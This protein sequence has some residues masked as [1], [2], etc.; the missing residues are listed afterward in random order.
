MSTPAWLGATA[1]ASGPGLAAQVN[2]FLGTHASVWRY[3]GSTLVSAQATGAAVYETTASQYWAQAITTG[4]SQTVIGQLGLQVSTVG[5]SPTSA[6]IAPLQVSL[7]AD[8]SGPTGAALA[9][10]TLAETYVYSAPFWLPVPLSV[11]GLTPSTRY[12]VVTAPVGNSSAYYVWQH[13]NQSTGALVS[14]DAVTWSNEAFGLMY[15]VYDASGT[16]QIT[17]FTDDDGARVTVLTYDA[18]NR[19][20]TITEYTTAQ[21]GALLTSTRTLTYSGAYLTGVS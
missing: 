2:Q 4:S 14:S 15:Q 16:G 10:V 12:W 20:S 13:S 17:S 18:S 3:T 9:G 7:Y 11:T 1:G 6:T 5:G 8:S 21:G 19:V